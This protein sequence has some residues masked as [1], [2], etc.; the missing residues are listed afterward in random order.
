MYRATEMMKRETVKLAHRKTGHTNINDNERIGSV[1][2]GAVLALY[3]LSRKSFGGTLLALIGSGLIHRGV[4]GHCYVYEL[5]GKNTSH[6]DLERNPRASVPIDR[7]VKLMMMVHVNRPA[8][9]LYRFWRDFERLPTI[10]SHLDSVHVT[11][12]GRSHWIAKAPMGQRVEWDAEII[13]DKPGQFIAWRS[14]PGADIPNAGSVHF[15]PGPDG[16][17]TQVKVFL[18]YDTPAGAAGA[19]L[20]KL[21][22]EN[23]ERQ[24]RDDLYRFKELMEGRRAVAEKREEPMAPPQS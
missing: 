14:L 24:L 16:H 19:L 6:D 15:D 7:G 21:F 17:G 8:E 3:G 2:G 10:M 5:I 23:P 11:A 4:T 1:V 12:E 22:T 20:A 9:E 13:N 18:K